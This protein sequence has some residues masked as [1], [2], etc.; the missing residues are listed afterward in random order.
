[1]SSETDA[2][3]EDSFAVLQHEGSAFPL[4]YFVIEL[5]GPLVSVVIFIKVPFLCVYSF[6][7]SSV[8]TWL[9]VSL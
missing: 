9:M 8:K 4:Q 7:F 2:C 5:I 3:M 1:M 6:V